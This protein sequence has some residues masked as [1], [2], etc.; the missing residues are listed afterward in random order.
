MKKQQTAPVFIFLQKAT[1]YV[2][3]YGSIKRLFEEEKEN[4][5][6]ALGTFYNTI[7]LAQEDYE[8]EEVFVMKRTIHRTKQNIL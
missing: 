4:I 6:I 7:D 1:L 8:T 3:A 5:P 2:A